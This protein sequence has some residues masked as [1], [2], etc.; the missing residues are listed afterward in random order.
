LK[1]G[2]NKENSPKLSVASEVGVVSGLT[3][4]TNVLLIS[5]AEVVGFKLAVICLN[6]VWE[7]GTVT[8]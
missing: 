8:E 5:G 2:G 4:T 1:V 3:E 7:D 6:F